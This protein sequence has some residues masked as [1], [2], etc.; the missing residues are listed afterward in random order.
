M[1]TESPQFWTPSDGDN[2]E[3][4]VTE[5]KTPEELESFVAN[6]KYS[7]IINTSC[8][9]DRLTSVRLMRLL[10]PSISNFMRLSGFNRPEIQTAIY[11][12]E[13]KHDE[14]IAIYCGAEQVKLIQKCD[15]EELTTEL[16]ELLEK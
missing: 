1:S 5:L 12:H 11:V 15:L 14:S 10:F 9:Y 8:D 6:G 16:E 2:Y 7:V 4:E 3:C 13:T